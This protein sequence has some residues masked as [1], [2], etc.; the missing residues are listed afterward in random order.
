[1]NIDKEADRI[2]NAVTKWGPARQ[3]EYGDIA[4]MCTWERS[5]LRPEHTNDLRDMS[6]HGTRTLFIIFRPGRSMVATSGPARPLL[7]AP[8]PPPSSPPPGISQVTTLDPAPTT[9]ANIEE[10]EP[11]TVTDAQSLAGW[12]KVSEP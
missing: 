11:E 6:K 2:T 5:I 12:S 3:L 9:S 4:K 1:M 8:P 7:C 10:V